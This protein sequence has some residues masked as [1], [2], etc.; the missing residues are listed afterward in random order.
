MNPENA[1]LFLAAGIAV[2][3]ALLWKDRNKD[4]K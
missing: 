2:F 4:F 3:L 1:D